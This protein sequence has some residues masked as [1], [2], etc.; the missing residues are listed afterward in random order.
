MI[1]KTFFLE[2]FKGWKGFLLFIIVLTMIASGFAHLYPSVAEGFEA[3][4]EFYGEEFVEIIIEDEQIYLGWIEFDLL[5]EKMKDQLEEDD[6]MNLLLESFESMPLKEYIWYKVVEDDNP[7]MAIYWA[8]NSTSK[9]FTTIDHQQNTVRYFGVIAVI[10]IDAFEIYEEFAIGV[11]STETRVD[12]LEELMDT[13][14]V[15]LFTAGRSDISMDEIDGFLSVEIYSWWILLVGIYLAYLSCKTI[16]DDFE[17]RRMDIVFSTTLSKKR[18][19]FEKYS[20]F[21]FFVFLMHLIVGTFLMLSVY[22]VTGTFSSSYLVSMLIAVPMFIVIIAVSMLFAIY[23]KNSR[24]AVGGSFAVILLSY[25][26]Y[27]TG[28]LVESLE[29]IHPLTLSYYWD[30]N[31]VLLDNIVYPLHLVLL[32]IVSVILIVVS[33]KIFQKSDIPC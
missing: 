5:I 2:F 10:E 24:R 18:Y 32:I 13:P 19:I 29:V 17:Q 27:V 12:P 9:N 4:E 33:F 1:G 16:T 7:Y 28:H 6:E 11:V 8:I 31:S 25:G 14:W 20:A 30:Y 22:S 3:E 23:F 21:C 26:F 15:R